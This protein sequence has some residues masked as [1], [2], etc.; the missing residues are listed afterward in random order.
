MYEIKVSFEQLIRL[1]V[2]VAN[3]IQEYQEFLEDP[4]GIGNNIFKITLKE[5]QELA[6]RLSD[7]KL[8]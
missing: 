2:M 8:K 6:E 3:K 5:L 4:N 7:A 1:Q